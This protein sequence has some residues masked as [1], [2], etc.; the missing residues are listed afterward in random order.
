MTLP[1]LPV[2]APMETTYRPLRRGWSA[3]E[4]LRGVRPQ[5]VTC[6]PAAAR[7]HE[8]RIWIDLVAEYDARILQRELL[9]RDADFTPEFLSFLDAWAKD[10]EHHAAGLLRLYSLVTGEAEASVAH[11]LDE[12]RGDFVAR[13]GW[14]ADEFK[15]AVL[16]AYDEAMSTHG[17]GGDIPFYS[18]LGPPQFGALLREL[19]NDEAMH[20]RNA[21]ELLAARHSDRADEVPAVMDEI[22]AFDAAQDEYRATFVLDHA[23]SQ[24]PP[25]MMARVGRSVCTA[26]QRAMRRRAAIGTAPSA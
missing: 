1:R 15:L 25:E 21:L 20:Y 11:R 17:Y 3:E 26:L 14:L 19:K 2:S 7:E 5:D 13:G 4:L 6:T 22:V 8:A 23:T 12:R 9:S 10:E 18:S 16:V 24:Y